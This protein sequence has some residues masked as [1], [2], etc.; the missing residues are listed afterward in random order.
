MYTHVFTNDDMT[1][2]QVLTKTLL[3]HHDVTFAAC[4]KRHPLEDNI[5]VSFSVIPEGKDEIDVLKE[6]VQRLQDMFQHLE[7]QF[8]V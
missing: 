2:A 3:N 5:D 1:M 6:C 8:G 4:K 7:E